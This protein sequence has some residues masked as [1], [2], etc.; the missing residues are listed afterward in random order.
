MPVLG[1]GKSQ[2]FPKQIPKPKG[3]IVPPSAEIKKHI[4][5]SPAQPAGITL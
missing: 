3:S 5:T 2:P 4:G 1:N